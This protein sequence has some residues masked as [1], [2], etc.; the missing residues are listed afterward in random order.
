MGCFKNLSGPQADR[1]QMI[2]LFKKFNL[3]ITI[4]TNLTITDFLD[5]TLDL[6]KNIYYP[7]IK[8]NN[9]TLYIH[10]QSNHPPSIIRQLPK[11]ISK[12]VSDISSSK[13]QFLEAKSTYDKAL[14][15]SGFKE[16]LQYTPHIKA[17]KKNRP[18][19]ITWFNP[20]FNHCVK[21][22]VGKQFKQLVE[23]HFPKYHR[24][25]KLFNKNNLKLSYCSIT[26]IS[27]IIS[28]HNKK[29]LAQQDAPPSTLPTSTEERMSA[30]LSGLQSHC[31]I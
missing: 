26:N 18:R 10:A 21:S 30:V 29:I 17:D 6:Q 8:P 27:Q 13:A 28:S 12:R 19:K 4:E 23:T 31:Q 3:K 20:P 7:Y 22:N 1:K 11:M 5:V 15:K 2:N 25:N 24:Y 14:Q 9:E 16:T